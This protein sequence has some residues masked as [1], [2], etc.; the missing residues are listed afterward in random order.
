MIEANIRFL[1]LN[2]FKITNDGG[3]TTYHTEILLSNMV[4]KITTIGNPTHHFNRDR[5]SLKN[6]YDLETVTNSLLK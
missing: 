4:K 1:Y 5:N 2:V 3:M 6:I